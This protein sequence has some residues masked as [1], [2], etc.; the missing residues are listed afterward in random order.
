MAAPPQT[1]GNRPPQL[2]IGQNGARR[3]L[4]LGLAEAPRAVLDHRALSP[5]PP[6]AFPAGRS[7]GARRGSRRSSAGTRERRR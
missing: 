3:A 7:G 5:D 6:C 2:R 1:R 4:A